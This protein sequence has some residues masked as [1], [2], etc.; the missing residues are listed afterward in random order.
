MLSINADYFLYLF[1]IITIGVS[2]FLV[3]RLYTIL[4]LPYEINEPKIEIEIARSKNPFSRKFGK[5]PPPFP[6]SWFRIAFSKEI[7]VGTVKKV[8]VLGHQLAIFRGENERVCALDAYCP[9]LGANLGDGTVTGNCIQCPF[10]GWEFN[11]SDGKCMRIPYNEN[12]PDFARAKTYTVLESN[13]MILL[14]H[15]AENRDIQWYPPFEIKADDIS[16]GEF[17]FH[18]S[19]EHFITCHIQDIPEN[20]PDRAHLNF[21]HKKLILEWIPMAEHKWDATWQPGNEKGKD[22][23]LAYINLTQ[24]M[25]IAGFRIPGTFISVKIIQIGPGLVQLIFNTFLGRIVVIESVTP[26]EP[27][28]QK[29]GHVVFA[30]KKVPRFIAKF[31]LWGLLKQFERDVPIWNKKTFIS[32]PLVVKN[33]GPLL[34]YRRWMAKFYSENSFRI[35]AKD[36]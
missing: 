3:K 7:P 21:L 10:H 34:V 12:V 16:N 13:N 24:E 35:E 17:L 2:G 5:L 33:D 36:W 15:D 1:L 26:I 23:H 25:V 8:D 19:S 14:W 9:H 18:G 4:F 20:G 32:Q 11:G 6:N 30:E 28:L 31:V 22:E 29:A 27:L